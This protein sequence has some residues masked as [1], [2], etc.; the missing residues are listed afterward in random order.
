MKEAIFIGL[1]TGIVVGLIMGAATL[2]KAGETQSQKTRREFKE[3]C[4][5]VHGTAVWNNKYWECL[6]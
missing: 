1:V 5:S 4:E 3:V 2:F 6:K